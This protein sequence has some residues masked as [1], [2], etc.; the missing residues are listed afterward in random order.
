MISYGIMSNNTERILFSELVLQG[1]GMLM[2]WNAFLASLDWFYSSFPTESPGFWLGITSFVGAV[3]FQ[4]LTTMFGHHFTYNLRIVTSYII[5]SVLLALTP[6]IVIFS[7]ERTGFILICVITSIGGGI[8]AISEASI[9]AL[10]GTLPNK[11]TNAV[12]IGNGLSGCFITCLRLICLGAFPQDSSGY[13]QSTEVYF[14]ISG[15]VLILCIIA[16]I[17][18]MKNPLVIECIE[19]TQT[20]EAKLK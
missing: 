5:L 20:K 18:T 17:H 10:A 1:I 19:N 8:N 14:A 7:T 4:P 16:Q 13:L 11:F 12:V 15:G 3:V 2:S 6:A 9:Y